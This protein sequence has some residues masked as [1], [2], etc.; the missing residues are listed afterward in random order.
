M[1]DRKETLEPK[2]DQISVEEAAPAA[3]PEPISAGINA[4]AMSTEVDCLVN[5]EPE[6]THA[7]A[8]ADDP[9][10]IP[11]VPVDLTDIERFQRFREWLETGG[12]RYEVWAK[13]CIFTS[14]KPPFLCLEYPQGFRAKHA[15]ATNRDERLLRGVRA[16]FPDC[17]GVQVRHRVD[18]SDRM[19]HRETVAHEKAEAQ[20]QLERLVAENEDV[21]AIVA[22]FDAAIASVH[23]DHR[24]PTPPVLSI[25]EGV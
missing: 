13:D 5:G 16:F 15:S 20:A 11:V 2:I 8:D 3:E 17:T 7:D 24:S 1:V 6:S 4:D 9:D 12:P 21:V 25:D 23:A 10:A 18:E 22:Q 19:T 14:V